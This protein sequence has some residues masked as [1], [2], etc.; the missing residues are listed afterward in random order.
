MIIQFQ[1]ATPTPKEFSFETDGVL[2]SG[3]FEKVNNKLVKISSTIKG[4][5]EVNCS[6]CSKKFHLSLDEDINFRVSNGIY[7]EKDNILEDDIV[8]TY[9]ETINFDEIFG[10]EIESIRNDFNFCEDCQDD[11]EEFE[12]QII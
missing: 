4:N 1:K 6:R 2:I 3:T 11:S 12:T 9:D 10:S 5:L 7:K 8:E